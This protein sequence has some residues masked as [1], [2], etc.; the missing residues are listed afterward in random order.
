MCRHILPPH[1]P[2]MANI[3]VYNTACNQRLH[4]IC[5]DSHSATLHS[6]NGTLIE[7]DTAPSARLASSKARRW[8]ATDAVH[9]REESRVDTMAYGV[10]VSMFDLHRSDRGS[11]PGRGGKI[12]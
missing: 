1:T 5:I 10:V 3:S 8:M 7:D 9:N 4:S 12:S 11:N 2:A 6:Y